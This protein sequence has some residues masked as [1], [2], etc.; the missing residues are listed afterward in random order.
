K[1]QLQTNRCSILY[2][3]QHKEHNDEQRNGDPKGHVSSSAHP[4]IESWSHFFI[5]SSSHRVIEKI[6]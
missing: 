3:K 2:A 5:D 4:V 6:A 1:E